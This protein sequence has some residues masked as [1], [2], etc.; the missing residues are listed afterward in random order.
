MSLDQS[1]L[2]RVGQISQELA[3]HFDSVLIL[4]TYRDENGVTMAQV[5][6]VGNTFASRAVAEAYVDGTLVLDIKDEDEPD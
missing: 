2:E 5:A 6:D 3:P 1:L 4:C